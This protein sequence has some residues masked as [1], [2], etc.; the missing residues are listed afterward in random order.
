MEKMHTAYKRYGNEFLDWQDIIYD[1]YFVSLS[2]SIIH[3]RWGVLYIDIIDVDLA[4]YD[5]M[6]ADIYEKYVEPRKATY[7]NSSVGLSVAPPYETANPGPIGGEADLVLGDELV[8]IKVSSNAVGTFKNVCQLSC[9]YYMMAESE[10]V[11][12]MK[13]GATIETLS[14]F[15]PLRGEITRY[16]VPPDFYERAK[17]ILGTMIRARDRAIARALAEPSRAIPEIPQIEAAKKLDDIE[18]VTVRE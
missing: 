14:L 7:S 13:R 17:E 10:I 12:G 1:I 8:D 4:K 18:H 5:G 15:N 16:E 11:P 9:Y 2:H 3:D 6:Y